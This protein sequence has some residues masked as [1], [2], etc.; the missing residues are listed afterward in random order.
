MVDIRLCAWLAFIQE[1]LSHYGT[2]AV[3]GNDRCA[4][5]RSVSGEESNFIAVVLEPIHFCC[6]QKLNC[7]DRL[8]CL[9]QHPM[10][11]NSMQDNIGVFES[12]YER[13]SSRN[14]NNRLAVDRVQHRDCF[15]D[16]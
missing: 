7:L 1:L 6:R 16:D 10:K 15:R 11:I 8:A 14:S 5:N 9:Q 12:L 13:S 4:L 2:K 3:S